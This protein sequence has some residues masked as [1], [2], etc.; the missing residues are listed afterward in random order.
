MACVRLRLST[1]KYSASTIDCRSVR[2]PLHRFDGA[3]CLVGS[4]L[5]GSNDAQGRPVGHASSP[6]QSH[7]HL[8]IEPQTSR[9]TCK[10]IKETVALLPSDIGV[11]PLYSD[12]KVTEICR[13]FAPG[14]RAHI[15]CH[16]RGQKGGHFEI[17][18]SLRKA[19]LGL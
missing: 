18:T 5:V 1:F 15:R 7:E 16:S 3:E 13:I 11:W 17:V 8:R 12:G 19:T 2:P 10:E 9:L 4:A 6:M 14:S